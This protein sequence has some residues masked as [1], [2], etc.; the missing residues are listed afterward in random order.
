M[1]HII[2]INIEVDNMSD[3]DFEELKKFAEKLSKKKED[4]PHTIRIM[5]DILKR[6][7]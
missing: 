7:R 2:K 4:R 6:E 1:K 3:K 5:D